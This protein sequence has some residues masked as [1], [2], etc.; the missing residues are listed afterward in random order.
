MKQTISAKFHHTQGLF[1]SINFGPQRLLDPHLRLSQTV[2]VG[3]VEGVSGG[4]GV[5]ASRASLLQPQV[6]E[7]F[8]ET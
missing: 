4:G 5:H 6:V 7:D 3:D 2:V 1:M 8:G